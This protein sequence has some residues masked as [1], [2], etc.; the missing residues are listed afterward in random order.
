M[1]TAGSRKLGLT[2]TSI[3]VAVGLSGILAVAGVRLVVNQM[4][5]LRVMELI[6]KGD[7]IYKF[8][9]N[10]LHD[11]KVWWCTLYEGKEVN[12]PPTPPNPNQALRDCIFG[13][14]GGSCFSGNAG[15]AMKLMGPDCK[16]N[17]P[18]VA[19]KIKHR[20]KYDPSNL[21]GG[22]FDFKADYG[23]LKQFES[24]SVTFI[25]EGGK[26]LKDSVMVEPSDGY[27]WWN[28][29]LR[30]TEVGNN[31]VDLI[32]TQKFDADKWR[33]A[34]AAGKR[35]LPELNYPR[36]FR[37]RRSTNYLQ[38]PGCGAAA[39]TSIA[40][41]TD[42]RQLDCHPSPLVRTVSTVD[43]LSSCPT[44]GGQIGAVVESTTQ[45]SH[46]DDRVSVTPVSCEACSSA[47]WTIGSGAGAPDRN[48]TCALEGVGK[49]INYG[50]RSGTGDRC[51][52]PFYV[53]TSDHIAISGICANGSR[54][55]ATLMGWPKNT[56][57]I[58]ATLPATGQGD[59]GG[60]GGPG[61]GPKGPDGPSCA[62]PFNWS[63]PYVC[64]GGP[65]PDSPAQP[66]PQ[67]GKGCR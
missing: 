53:G 12:P 1:L 2:L 24:S 42:N 35:H 22:A 4:N 66:Q 52:S 9:S 37:V 26:T 14:G 11:D 10:L 17:E 60:I 44:G 25:R 23:G 57:E 18:L 21:G 5:A 54:E 34:P 28:V 33:D 46:A 65:S 30:W 15:T 55:Y 62:A 49:M 19:G 50:G 59:V 6:D 20:F 56:P 29:E 3:M 7:A 64:C 13:K 67:C 58:V 36:E 51:G 45:C 48:V 39:V 27:G 47:I 63:C 41:H 61:T 32:F 40:L 31:A 38:D 8:Y 43:G 16:F